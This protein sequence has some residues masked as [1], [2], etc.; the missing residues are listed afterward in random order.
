MSVGLSK[1]IFFAH[2]GLQPNPTN[3]AKERKLDTAFDKSQCKVS[4]IPFPVMVSGNAQVDEGW[5]SPSALLK[6]PQISEESQTKD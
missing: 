4:Q 5:L 6:V 3:T 2:K 1:K